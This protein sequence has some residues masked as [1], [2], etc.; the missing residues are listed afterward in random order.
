MRTS[1]RSEAAFRHQDDLYRVLMVNIMR[2]YY[3]HPL[4]AFSFMIA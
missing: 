1:Q 2:L 3:A 4:Q